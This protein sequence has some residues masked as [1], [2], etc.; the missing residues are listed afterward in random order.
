MTAVWA[1]TTVY[2]AGA[3]ARPTTQNGYYYR[4]KF[5]G[6]SSGTEPGWPVVLGSTVTDG[7]VTWQC[8]SAVASE[9]LKLSPSAIVEMF[10]L[11][12]TALG[13]VVSRFHC[14]TNQLLA[15]LVWQGE[16]YTPTPIKAVGFEFSG[17]GKMP[18]PRLQISNISG[19]VSALVMTYGDL[20]G[21]K[22]TRKR[23]LFKYLDAVNFSGGVN[24]DADETAEFPDDIFFV[25]RKSTENKMLV[26]FEL[27]PAFDVQGVKLPRRQII[28]N[29]CPWVYRSAECSY[30]GGAVAKIDDTPTAILGEDACG[31]RLASCKLRFGEYDPLPF[32]GFPAAGLIR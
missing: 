4:A 6:T 21:A 29:V 20:L 16:T 13:G 15:S 10:V 14:G 2:A 11:D 30:A 28:Q 24:A 1:S 27:A 9:L 12:A 22:L 32:G 3:H 23:T 5:G 25:D 26:E 7:T 8:V 19:L 17:G 18:R 31:K